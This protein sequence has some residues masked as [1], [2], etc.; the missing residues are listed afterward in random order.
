MPY[1]HLVQALFITYR[2]WPM[3]VFISPNTLN[4]TLRIVCQNRKLY[5][6][7]KYPFFHS[8]KFITVNENCNKMCICIEDYT[9]GFVKYVYSNNNLIYK[10][11]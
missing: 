10:Y 4:S 7:K 9:I 11:T 5:G 3:R 6:Y 1:L 8:N 2:M